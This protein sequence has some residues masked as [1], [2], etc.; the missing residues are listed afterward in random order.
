MQN[1]RRRSIAPPRPLSA[2]SARQPIPPWEMEQMRSQAYFMETPVN[3]LRGLESRTKFGSS[4]G[5]SAL[6]PPP[7]RVPG[8]SKP[9]HGHGISIPAIGILARIRNAYTKALKAHKEGDV[10]LPV[11]EIAE[12][13]H[14][15]EELHGKFIGFDSP[16]NHRP[17]DMKWPDALDPHSLVLGAAV[18]TKKHLRKWLDALKG[19]RSRM[20]SFLAA[21][22]PVKNLLRSLMDANS[23]AWAKPESAGADVAHTS[24]HCNA[25]VLEHL[26]SLPLAT[27][28]VKTLPQLQLILPY[29]LKHHSDEEI[30]A[31][32]WLLLALKMKVP[33]DPGTLGALVAKTLV[34]SPEMLREIFESAM[35]GARDARRRARKH[36]IKAAADAALPPA[37]HPAASHGLVGGGGIEAQLRPMGS[38]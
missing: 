5:W 4:A 3:A 32:A 21:E 15:V 24:F 38:Y 26:A 12:W 35:A 11:P 37:R 1:P 10:D 33:A 6:P 9:R 29:L 25:S 28:V 19:I 18:D 27:L 8:K 7:I 13:V 14:S 34:K 20:G 16:F 17:C 22:A 23:L 30:A 2:A 31:D 36:A